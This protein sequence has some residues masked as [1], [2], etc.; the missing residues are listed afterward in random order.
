MV[1]AIGIGTEDTAAVVGRMSTGAGKG[2]TRVTGTKNNATHA[3]NEGTSFE[4]L[5][6]VLVGLPTL[7]HFLLSVARGKQRFLRPSPYR[8]A[9]G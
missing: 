6:W 5:H 2:I 9:L 4:T 7:Q 3:N 1:I 8:I